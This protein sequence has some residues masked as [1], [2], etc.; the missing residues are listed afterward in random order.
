MAARIELM[1][2]WFDDLSLVE[3]VILQ[4]VYYEGWTQD[5]INTSLGMS[6][7]YTSRVL[8]RALAKVRKRAEESHALAG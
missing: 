6:R 7:G 5:D 3:L 8:E 2:D 1:P 4:W